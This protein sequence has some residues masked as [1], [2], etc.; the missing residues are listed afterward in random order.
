MRDDVRSALDAIT[1]RHYNAG[2]RQAVADILAVLDRG[3][4]NA[5]HEW[6]TSYR[7]GG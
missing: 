6:L 1:Q 7:A 3:G 4:V 5:V 2:Y